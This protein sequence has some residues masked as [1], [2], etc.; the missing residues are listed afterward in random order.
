[1]VPQG[2]EGDTEGVDMSTQKAAA[3]RPEEEDVKSSGLKKVVTA[4]MAGTVGCSTVS[5]S[6]NNTW[7]TTTPTR[8][9]AIHRLQV[10]EIVRPAGTR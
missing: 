5:P 8:P 2:V 9:T 4:S 6:P 7:K 1:M 3:R 10:R